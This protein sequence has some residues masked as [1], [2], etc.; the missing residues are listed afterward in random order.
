M[1]TDTEAATATET[2]TETDTETKTEQERGKNMKTYEEFA[3]S[4]LNRLSQR[5]I[6]SARDKDEIIYHTKTKE[7]E[8]ETPEGSYFETSLKAAETLCDLIKGR[9]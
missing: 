6:K 8:V 1:D 7:Y 5:A 3:L 9:L 4:A 2:D